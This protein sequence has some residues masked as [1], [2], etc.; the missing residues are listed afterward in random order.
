MVRG[1]DAVTEDAVGVLDASNGGLGDDMWAGTDLNTAVRL[2]T[3][4]PSR[5][6]VGEARDLTRRLLLSSATPP[7]GGGPVADSGTS[8]LLAARVAGLVAIGAPGDAIELARAANSRQVPDHL[9]QS[10]VSANFLRSDLA[11]GCDVLDQYKGGYVE[12]FWQKALILCQIVGGKGAEASL[13]L[14]LLREERGDTDGVFQNIAYATAVGA[15]L[16]T[17]QLETPGTADILTFAMLTVAKAALPDW[18]LAS[19]DPALVRAMLASPQVEPAR[20]LALAHR[21][22]RRGLVD[23]GDVVAVY[24]GLGANEEAI[25]AALLDPDSVDHDVWL[26][27]L[28]LAAR[29]QSVAIARSEALWEAWTLAEAAEVDDIVLAT[30]AALLGDV[31]ATSSFGWLAAAATRAALIAGEDDL[32]IE[33]YQLVVRQ[34]RSVADMARATAL[35]W[36]EMRIIGRNLSAAPQGEPVGTEAQT[37]ASPTGLPTRIA[38]PTTDPTGRIP[39]TGTRAQ[40]VV[41]QPPRA[42]VPW[43]PTRLARWI[44]LAGN[45]AGTADI[46]MALYLLQ[47]L[48]DPVSEENWRSAPVNAEDSTQA[49]APIPSAA[50]LAGLARAAIA[51]RRAEVALYAMIVLGQA[52]ETPH[53]GVVANVV[54]SLQSVGLETDAQA[55]ARAALVAGV[56]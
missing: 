4:L 35:M 55:I 36:P 23:A 48:G 45:N 34:A 44:D 20:K 17:Q 18:M 29:N 41:T 38:A 10:I 53:A 25:A 7:D 52:G 6:P 8:R 32:A 30:T 54:R 46:G 9:A 31:P 5:Y 51:K 2:L 42:P 39:A 50:A 49:G 21:A 47:I 37:A 56:Q 22:L 33:W 40:L 15:Q 26:A 1:L 3:T 24:D 12:P 14:D 13:G 11:T 43:S 27:Y 28:Y 16:A 19:N